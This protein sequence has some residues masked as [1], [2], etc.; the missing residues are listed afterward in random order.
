[1]MNRSSMNR[2]SAAFLL[3]VAMM[4]SAAMIFS[5]QTAIQYIRYWRLDSTAPLK[6]LAISP[7][8]LAHDQY[9][10]FAH[11][12]YLDYDAT[13]TLDDV[14]YKNTYAAEDAAQEKMNTLREVWYNAK[15]PT[16][17]SLERRISYKQIAYTCVL[18]ALTAYFIFLNK[19]LQKT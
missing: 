5:V 4:A 1:M 7:K 14:N 2:S 11:Y 19:F 12:R 6:A 10:L 17:S 16:Y 13:Q 18:W 3:V 8:S 15:N 9:I